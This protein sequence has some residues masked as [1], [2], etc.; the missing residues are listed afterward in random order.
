MRRATS[1]RLL[2]LATCGVLS[3]ASAHALGPGLVNIRSGMIMGGVSG[4]EGLQGTVTTI[5]YL[6]CE[7]D[8]LVSSR[9][10]FVFRGVMA[11]DL[12]ENNMNYAYFG[13]G[14]RYFFGSAASFT[15]SEAGASVSIRPNNNYFVGWDAGVTHMIIDKIGDL[16][17]SSS[18]FDGGATAGMNYFVTDQI[19]ANFGA[20]VSYVFGFSSIS[21]SGIVFK[22]FGGVSF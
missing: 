20:S 10:A 8:L 15:R 3:C 19:A 17:V 14:Q 7:Y 2:T 1:Y 4:G 13:S 5:P 12:A 6:D 9:L 11:I 18:A 16:V 21:V 22:F